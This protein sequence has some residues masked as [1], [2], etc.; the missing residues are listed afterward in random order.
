MLTFTYAWQANI[1]VLIFASNQKTLGFMQNY[2]QMFGSV[3]RIIG[4]FGG[5]QLLSFSMTLKPFFCKS[6]E[7]TS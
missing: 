7:F 1:S 6:L 4:G 2:A 5:L 3:A